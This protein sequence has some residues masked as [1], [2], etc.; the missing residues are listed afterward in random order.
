MPR[1]YIVDFGMILTAD[2]P[3]D[4]DEVNLLLSDVASHK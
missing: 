3:V 4:K 2:P 1:S